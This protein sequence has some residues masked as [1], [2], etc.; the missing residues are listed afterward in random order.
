[1]DVEVEWAPF[2]LHPEFP[3]EGKLKPGGPGP[4]QVNSRLR[5]VGEQAGVNFTGLCPRFPNTVKAHCLLTFVLETQGA[6]AQN[7]VQ[8]ILFRHY[9]TDGLYPDINNLVAAAEEAGLD[10]EPVRHMLDERIYEQRVTAEAAEA[11]RSGVSGVPFF[12][13]NGQA[14]F[15]GAQPAEALL[16]ALQKA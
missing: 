11:S 2:L 3:E 5:E 9:F 16:K 13:F 1:M 14:G 8:E 7:K 6:V 4:H 15:S 12:S 10:G